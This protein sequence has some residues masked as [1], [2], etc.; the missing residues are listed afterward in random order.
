MTF[1]ASGSAT[2]RHLTILVSLLLLPAGSAMAGFF[3]PDVELLSPALVRERLQK[4]PLAFETG[5]AQLEV[6][7]KA[8]AIGGFLLGALLSSGSVSAG[9]GNMTAQQMGQ[10]MQANA[11]IAQAAN[12]QIQ[13]AVS[14]IGAAEAA[15]GAQD[16][17]SQGP[18]PLVAKSLGQLL[19]EQGAKVVTAG[20]GEAPA[21]QLRLR[22]TA[23]RLDF[24]LTSSDYTLFNG[25]RLELVD[26]K[27]DKV[28]VRQDCGG[29]YEKKMLLDDWERDG[30]QA[31]ALAAD[32]VAR[33]CQ[34]AFREALGLSVANLA[35]AADK[36]AAETPPV[37]ASTPSAAAPV[38]SSE[39]K[40]IVEGAA[41][42]G[43]AS[44][45]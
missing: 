30:Y 10:Q 35:V 17:A 31:L 12:P 13:R 28:H 5:G 37:E 41:G 43:R 7:T 19:L 42:L 2:F 3:G 18:L 44:E 9:N 26:T 8:A 36:P 29:E 27:A 14:D 40:P 32:E 15:R 11:T 34:K 6:R 45:K 16:I 39:A 23:W 33:E 20:A 4:Q 38:P 24:A 1:A 22:Q 25:L 21:L